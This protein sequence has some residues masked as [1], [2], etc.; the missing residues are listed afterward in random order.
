[1]SA[2]KCHIGSRAAAVGLPCGRPIVAA[3]PHPMPEAARAEFRDRDGN[4]VDHPRLHRGGRWVIA[5]T[6]HD[7]LASIAV[8]RCLKMNI[9]T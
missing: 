5:A 6:K 8:M 9:E 3:G 4:G 7:N 2:V 1:M